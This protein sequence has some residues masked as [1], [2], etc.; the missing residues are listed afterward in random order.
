[1]THKLASALF[2]LT[3][4][5]VALG[6][7]GHGH[8]WSQHVLPALQGLDPRI[9]ELL[10]LVWFWVSGAMFT[11]GVLLVWAWSRLRRGESQPAVLPALIGL[12]YCTEGVYGALYLGNFFLLFAVQ[13][14]LLWVTAWLM[15]KPPPAPGA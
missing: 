10:K 12:F 4:I 5:S 6:A 14:V 3:A 9:V 1:M 2:L 13:A 15:R 8:Q 7:F 11:F